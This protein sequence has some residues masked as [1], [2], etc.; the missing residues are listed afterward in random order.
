MLEMKALAEATATIVKAHVAE[1]VTPLLVRIETL[2]NSSPKVDD[3][4]IL[5]LVEQEVAKIPPAEKGKDADPEE[6]ASLVA[7]TVE[8]AVA[9]LP[10][11]QDGKSVAV[12][13][14]APLIV[15]EV[16]KAV[17][18]LP[19]PKSIRGV[20]VDRDGNAVF[21]YS[22]G[23]TENV[24]RVVGKDAQ[25]VDV[26]ALERLIAEKVDAIPRPKD[27]KDGFSL[28]D[29]DVSSGADGRSIIWSFEQGEN[30]FEV[31][32]KHPIPIYRDVFKEGQ[33]YEPG[34]M[35][36]WA[37]SVWHCCQKTTAKPDGPDSGW[38]LAVKK[39]RDGKDA[40]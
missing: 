23:S 10:V 20:V 11:P 39:G 3:V 26:A 27:G 16:G 6:V 32:M 14:V 35:V 29:F 8:R 40:K 18:A 13:D 7:E 24:G 1:A 28:T 25:E 21:T 37:G 4:A 34:D 9:A 19:V 2:E 33:E 30:R 36:T 38:K 22:D 12:E 15:E 17:A 5:R 31:E